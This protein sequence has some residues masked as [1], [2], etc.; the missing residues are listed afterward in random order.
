MFYY[1]FASECGKHIFPMRHVYTGN[2]QTW[3]I[4][5][6][7]LEIKHKLHAKPTQEKANYTYSYFLGM[8][9]E[10]YQRRKLYLKKC[11]PIPDGSKIVLFRLPMPYPFFPNKPVE[12]YHLEVQLLLQSMD[13]DAKLDYLIHGESY[14]PPPFNPYKPWATN[15]PSVLHTELFPPPP[16]GYVCKYCD[17]TYHFSEFCEDRELA[18]VDN[19]HMKRLPHGLPKKFLIRVTNP[20]AQTGDRVIFRDR[21]GEFWAVKEQFMDQFSNV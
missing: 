5:C 18:L 8:L 17:S 15:H 7:Y 11:A 4:A 2:H 16:L 9:Y 14:E 10:N 21:D 12:V 3:G 1:C 6:Y 13:E 19:F 20:T